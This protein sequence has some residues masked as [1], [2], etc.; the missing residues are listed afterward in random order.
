MAA[1]PMTVAAGVSADQPHPEPDAPDVGA[2]PADTV[3][4]T[5]VTSL[6]SVRRRA[7]SAI[8]ASLRHE[9]IEEAAYRRAQAR[10]FAAGQELEDWLA[11]EIE[12]DT[13]IRERYR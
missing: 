13:L 3:R 9:L 4:A 1:D 5:G 10:G 8:P 6:S 12:I 2:P 11:A 7:I